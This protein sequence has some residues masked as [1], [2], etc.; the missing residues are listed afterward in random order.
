[1]SNIKVDELSGAINKQLTLYSDNIT[2]EVNKAGLRAIKNLVKIT[3]ASAPVGKRRGH[4]KRSISYQENFAK[5]GNKI[6]YWYV[7]GSDYRLTH[8]LIN[9]HVTR[10]GGR[11]RG[12]DFLE[13]AVSEVIPSYENDVERILKND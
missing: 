8:L 13:K 10:N 7:K 12:S 5:R 9:G 3:K 4:Y 6:Y 2:N 1:M 11:T